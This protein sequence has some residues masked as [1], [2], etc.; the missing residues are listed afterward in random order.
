MARKYI[1][2]QQAAVA[3]DKAHAVVQKTFASA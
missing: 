2:Y 3:K 1:C